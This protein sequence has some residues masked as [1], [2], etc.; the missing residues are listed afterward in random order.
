MNLKLIILLTIYSNYLI[1]QGGFANTY[2]LKFNDRMDINYWPN[3]ISALTINQDKIYSLFYA[4]DTN[5]INR[6]SIYGTGFGVF[7][8]NGKLLSY[9]YIPY[10]GEHN[11]FYPEDIITYDYRTFYTSIYLEPNHDAILKYNAESGVTQFFS[12]Y[13]SLCHDDT[14]S[15]RFGDMAQD[16]NG[17]LIIAYDIRVPVPSDPFANQVQLVKMDTSGHIMW[18]KILG[19]ITKNYASNSCESVSVDNDGNYYVGVKYTDYFKFFET[20]LYKLDSNGNILGKYTSVYKLMTGNVFDMVHNED[21]SISLLSQWC[22]NDSKFAYFDIQAPAITILNKD[23]SLRKTFLIGDY[24]HSSLNAEKLLKAN[25][26]TDLVAI[27]NRFYN[28][29]YLKYDSLTNHLDTIKSSALKATFVRVSLNGDSIWQRK[30]TVREG[31]VNHWTDAEESHVYDLKALPDG[32]GYI[33]GGYSYRDNAYEV[34]G[35]AYYAPLLIRVDNDGCIIPGCNLV[36]S[37]KDVIHPQIS[38]R[39]WPSPFSDY[40]TIQH[41]ANQVLFYKI[42]DLTGKLMCDYVLSENG[43]NII[44]RTGHWPANLYILHV[45]DELGNLS[46][47]NLVKQ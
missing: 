23:L 41:D 26:S 4:T 10:Q 22:K 19:G 42:Y 15:I 2:V 9:N 17:H 39:V 14:C 46:I 16:V 33:M 35:E 34:L 1:A 43:E 5:A 40:I 6:N 36:N 44:I 7:D 20:I 29:N 38:Y 31:K 28:F 13:N 3:Y 37:N 45:S 47:K 11:Y 18:T 27:F 32:T 30:Y 24:L 8:L 21:G 25:H 12:I